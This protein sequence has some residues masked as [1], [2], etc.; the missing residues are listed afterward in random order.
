MGIAF[1]GV[2][3]DPKWRYEDVSR[4]PKSRRVCCRL[5]A[6]AAAAAAAATAVAA[7]AAAA[8]PA[9]AASLAWPG[10]AWLTFYVS[11]PACPA[12]SYAIMR[13]YMPT[14]GDLGRDMMFRSCTV[15]VNMQPCFARCACMLQPVALPRPQRQCCS[16]HQTSK[17]LFAMAGASA[18]AGGQLRAAVEASVC[19]GGRQPAPVPPLP[20]PPPPPRSS[21]GQPRF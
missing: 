21:T 1:L 5:Q 17:A 13:D 12:C 7:A 4:M 19:R 2:G 18:G 10:L 11:P 20:S 8:A 6:A 3:F 9:A 16:L 14:R 15:Q